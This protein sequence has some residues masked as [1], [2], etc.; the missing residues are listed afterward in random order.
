MC[1]IEKSDPRRVGEEIN[2]PQQLSPA[3]LANGKAARCTKDFQ[4][5]ADRGTN[6][7]IKTVSSVRMPTVTG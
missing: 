7:E 4:T 6:Y 2:A 1:E 3:T 5:E